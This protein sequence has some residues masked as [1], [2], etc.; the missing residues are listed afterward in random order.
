MKFFILISAL[1]AVSSAYPY[2]DK[3]QH[4]PPLPKRYKRADVSIT[5]NLK[6]GIRDG[7]PYLDHKVN[8]ANSGGHIL[9]AHA[10]VSKNFH[11]N[12][13]LQ[14]GG[15]LNYGHPS[16]GGFEISGSKIP[17]GGSNI[18]AAGVYNLYR[19]G[20]FGVD[21]KGGYNQNFGGPRGNGPPIVDVE[22]KG[23]YAF[24]SGR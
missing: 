16:G 13:P 19:N 3:W 24:P 4:Q 22:I 6:Y 17:G 21:F 2:I 14:T 23:G 15:S 7:V 20:G 11:G 5:N 9:D 10:H 1:S 12:G 8:L 18:G